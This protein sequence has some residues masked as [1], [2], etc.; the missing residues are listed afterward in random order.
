MDI[1]L[2]S[3]MVGELVRERP[4][5]GLPGL[6]TFISEF[7]PASFSDR[8]YTINPPYKR[9]TFV[10]GTVTDD[11]L[12]ELYATSNGIDSDQ[13]RALLQHFLEGTKKVLMDRKTVVF[14]GLGRLR[15]TRQNNIFFITDETL[16]I[17]PEGF[18]LEPV[19]LK[20]HEENP[21]ELHHVVESLAD[22]LVAPEAEQG[23]E[24]QPAPAAEPAAA[25][26]PDEIV[27][28]AG[29]PV[30]TE[31]EAAKAEPEAAEAPEAA[32]APEAAKAERKA[33]R[34]EA[35]AAR[36]A[37]RAAR[38]AAREE[39]RAARKAERAERRARRKPV[40]K[41]VWLAPLL[42]VAVAAFVAAA[43]MILVQVAPDFIDTL[44]YTPE[45]LRIINY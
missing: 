17:Y 29:E 23:A 8:G 33:A 1:E 35:R 37:D 41:W 40:S 42:L 36:K 38:K 44:L 21:A 19:S 6:G 16:D 20:N 28:L 27:E 31:P 7:V 2:L 39:A 22:I 12:V 13:A 45:E 18:G 11:S 10:P 26:A 3:K 14:P 9:V 43:F 30:S 24:P 34:E 15:A 5:V 4:E 32:P 25:S